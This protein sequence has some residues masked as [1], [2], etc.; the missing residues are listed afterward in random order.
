MAGRATRDLTEG[1]V[2]GHIFRMLLPMSFGILAMMLVGIIDTYWVGTLGTAQQAAVQMSFPVTML[3]MSVSIGLGAGAVSAV[4]RAAGRKDG[5]S[6]PRMATDALTLSFI[7]V[8]LV[9]ILGIIFVEPM[10]RALGASESMLPYVVEYMT[11]WFGGI[12]LIVGP[13]VASN[14][15]RALG[16]AVVPSLM[17]I[18]AAFVNLILDPI[19]ILDDVFGWFPGLGWGVSGAALATV[20]ANAVTFV[21]VMVYLTVKEKLI[22]WSIPNFAEVWHHWRDIARVGIPA[23]FAN[24]FNPFALTIA[25]SGLGMA[26]FGDAAVGG[27]GVAGRVEAFAIVPLFALSAS[28]GAVTGQN[29]GAERLDRVREAFRSSFV[30]CI[31]WSVAMAVLLWL[32]ADAIAAA[33]LPSEDGRA[34]AIAYWHIVPLTVAGYGITIAASAGF[35]GLG[36]PGHGIVITSGRAIGLMVPFV[37]IGAQWFNQPVGVIYGV[38]AANLLAGILTA[39]FVLLRAPMT[40]KHTSTRKNPSEGA[41]AKA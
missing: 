7:S 13:M 8:G 30:F 23:C 4:S 10:F 34:V 1:P 20:V 35:N 39:A 37:I 38:A 2:F 6:I 3:V 16:N 22:D 5:T 31:G 41:A 17:M 40:A 11:V 25:M 29:G 21:M 14:I 15:L 33:F 19:F 9:S 28:I 36:R 32:F 24:V 18:A 26:R 27:L 12:V